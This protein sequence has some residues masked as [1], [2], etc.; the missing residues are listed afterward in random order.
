MIHMET[1][2]K[3][4]ERIRE[5]TKEDGRYPEIPIDE[6]GYRRFNGLIL[7]PRTL[8]GIVI[9]RHHNDIRE[10]HPG[11]ARTVEKIQRNYY[12]PGI[13]RKVRKHI[14]A[15]DECQRNKPK[16]QK[17]YG[18]MQSNKVPER[19]WQHLTM[20]FVDMP[21][22]HGIT[23]REKWNQIL[24]IVDRFSKSTILIPARKNLTAREVYHILWEKV[25]AVFGLP[26]T[27]VTDMDKIFRSKEWIQLMKDLGIEQLLSTAHHQQTDGQSER[28]IQELQSYLRGYLDY[29]Q[30][31]WIELLPIAQ[32]ALNDAESATTKVTPNFAVFGTIRRNGLDQ[33]IDGELPISQQM[34][35]THKNISQEIAWATKEY[36]H[37]Y[38]RRRRAAPELSK[39]TRVYLKRRATGNKQFN[40]RTMRKSTKMD[41]LQL[42]PFTIE[43]KLMN[44]NYRL[45][46]PNSM[47]IHPI[48]HISLLEPTGNQETT[49]EPIAMD[50]TYEVEKI[51]GKRARKGKIEYLV[52]WVGY[53]ESENTWEP[54][55][56]LNCPE[57]VREFK[58]SDSLRTK[59]RERGGL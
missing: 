41:S 15:C 51:L 31:N 46:L 36:K 37:Y 20:D 17:P 1:Q 3:I 59:N 56:H 47:R 54:T 7:V 40:I 58:E 21:E 13:I 57:R 2:D 29:E 8:E 38:D 4:M 6:N 35:I 39:G 50:D 45:A 14:R 52:K 34:K 42:G 16:Q 9:E 53:D 18:K 19:P 43:E 24:V 28:K 23:D 12:F 32:Y 27:I 10:G 44:D 26:E 25:F 11:E 55:H 30:T 22:T 33:R 48:F 49:A 5:E